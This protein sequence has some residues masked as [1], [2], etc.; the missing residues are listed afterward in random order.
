MKL[1]RSA[2][3]SLITALLPSDDENTAQDYDDYALPFLPDKEEE[4]EE[5]VKVKQIVESQKSKTEKRARSETPKSDKKRKRLYDESPESNQDS[6]ASDEYKPE[7]EESSSEE[8]MEEVVENLNAEVESDFIVEDDDESDDNL[9]VSKK[10]ESKKSISSKL[11]NGNQNS[12]LSKSTLSKLTAFNA[13]TSSPSVDDLSISRHDWPHLKYD[14][15]QPNSIRDLYKRRPDDPEYDNTT[16][17]I[18]KHHLDKQTPCH[19]QWWEFKSKNFDALLLFK[20]GKFY[21]L[22]HM[23]AVIAVNELHINFMKGEIAHA[24]FPEKAY[25]DKADVLIQR[26]YK[27]IRIEQTETP[28]MMDQRIKKCPKTVSKDDKVVRREICQITTKGT[29]VCS[30]L[31]AETSSDHNHFLMAICENVSI[32][33]EILFICKY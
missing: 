29:R 4:E 6:D 9:V 24:G 11:N 28:Q 25:K 19:K 3:A 23:D 10:N 21:E 1:E 18:P 32:V 8:S 13:S 33:K 2:R 5:K 26:G 17:F 15:L 12:V 7:K 27:V 31:D 30:V 20:M 16:L 22:F 14:F